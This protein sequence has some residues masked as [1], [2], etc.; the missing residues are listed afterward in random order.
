MSFNITKPELL[1]IYRTTWH[2]MDDLP[3]TL[4]STG[5][6]RGWQEAQQAM[7]SRV[8]QRAAEISWGTDHSVATRLP[9]LMSA[10]NDVAVSAGK[11][12]PFTGAAKSG[13]I[14]EALAAARRAHSAI[15]I[16]LMS[17]GWHPTGNHFNW[18]H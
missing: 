1:N 8:S 13:N 11:V 18:P 14:A 3:R 6:S 17:R 12:N 9:N 5:R 7:L 10:L 15:Q 2:W 16:E 4:A